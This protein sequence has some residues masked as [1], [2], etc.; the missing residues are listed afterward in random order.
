MPRVAAVDTQLARE[1]SQR[2]LMLARMR[3][4]PAVKKRHADEDD[5]LTYVPV[6]ESIR[7]SCFVL[8]R[9]RSFTLLL[10]SSGIVV[11]TW[12]LV[13]SAAAVY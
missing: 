1:N 9:F 13:R 5:D 6:G 10:S 3:L 7:A 2:L 8:R 11:A 12:Q 4:P